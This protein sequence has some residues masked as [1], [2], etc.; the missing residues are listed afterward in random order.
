MVVWLVDSRSWIGGGEIKSAGI[1]VVVVV[2]WGS[3]KWQWQSSGSGGGA[4]GGGKGN[5]SVVA[6]ARGVELWWIG[7][8]AVVEWQWGLSGGCWSI[9][10][11][12]WW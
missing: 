7:G 6:V 9:V 10:G 1:K 8:G 4:E 3:D 5:L 2:E 11:G 12:G